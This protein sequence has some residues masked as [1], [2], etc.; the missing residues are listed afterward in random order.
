MQV[1]VR[2]QEDD[3]LEGLSE[4]G[5]QV[6]MDRSPKVGG[7][8]LG[9]RPMEML[10]LGLGGCA[11]I[12]V[13]LILRKSRQ[14]FSDIRVD[15]D[16]ERAE[17]IPQVFTRIHLHFVVTA[18]EIDPSRIERAISLSAEKYCSASK[19]LDSVA[20]I[21]HDFEILSG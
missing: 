16:A 20:Q 13:I 11:L 21:T 14:A 6:L 7:Q 4:S 10:L 9:A 5:H 17:N 3:S 12:D 2:L 19:M 18:G 8:N 1:T 15:I